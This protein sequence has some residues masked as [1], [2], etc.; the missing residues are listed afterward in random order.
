MAETNKNSKIRTPIFI[1]LVVIL[2][3]GGLYFLSKNSN[4]PFQITLEENDHFKGNQNA[5]V[6]LVE[7][8]DFSCPACAYYFPIVEKLTANYQNDLLFIY[9]H[10]PFHQNSYAAA[11]ASEAANKQGA[12]WQMAEKLYVNQDE[13]AN[14]QNPSE[15][16]T[17]YAKE[18][19]LNIEQFKNDLNSQE[20]G[21][22]VNND[23]N[24]G[25]KYGITYTPSFFVNGIL[26]NNPSSYEEFVK[27]IENAK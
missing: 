9:R 21:Q 13:W 14:S 22:K 27:I 6:V 11:L 17:S 12:F 10:F 19:N 4:K 3:I 24:S 7:Y 5:P 20:I 25:K 15:I 18:L 16:F 8:S 26:I 1:G 2:V 23:F